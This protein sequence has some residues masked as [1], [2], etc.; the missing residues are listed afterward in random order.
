MTGSNGVARIF[1]LGGPIFRD[2]RRPTRFGG[3]GGGVVAEIFRHRR[4]P[5]RFSGEGGVVPEIFRH[6]RK[7]GRF[8]GGGG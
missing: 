6:R 4:K 1:F 3:G 8:S 7:P 2:V 5:G